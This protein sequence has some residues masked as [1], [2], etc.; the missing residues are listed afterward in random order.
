MTR[1]LYN[2]IP[3]YYKA[4]LDNIIVKGLTIT[5]RDNQVIPGI[6]QYITEYIQNIDK[7]L[8]NVELVEYTVNITKS[9]WYQESTPI[10]RY[11]CRTNDHR[12]NQAK[13]IKILK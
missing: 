12:L 7:V 11:I 9:Q 2:L 1:I 3:T 8:V 13:I 4:F 6:R 5:Y 10:I